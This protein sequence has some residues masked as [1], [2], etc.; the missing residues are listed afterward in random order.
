MQVTAYR[1]VPLRAKELKLEVGI[2]RNGHEFC[3]AR[4]AQDGLISTR[5]V[6]YLEVEHLRPKVCSSSKCDG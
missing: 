2:I 1:D 4:S 5:E 3:I 6:D